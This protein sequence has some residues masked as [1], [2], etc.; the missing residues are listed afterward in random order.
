MAIDEKAVAR[1]RAVLARRRGISEKK[2]MGALCFMAGG[3]MCCGVTGDALMVRVGRENFAA[4]LAR[5]HARPLKIGKRAARGFVLI[6]PPGYRTATAL[7]RWVEQGLT[8]AKALRSAPKRPAAK[9][10]K[11]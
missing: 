7:T 6:D 3:A 4:A 10:G 2:M 8:V 5:P 1:L 11:R 9:R